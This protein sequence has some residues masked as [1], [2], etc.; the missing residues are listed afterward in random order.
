MIGSTKFSFSGDEFSEFLK[1]LN[2][3]I[4]F[5]DGKNLENF[6]E[7]QRSVLKL[8]YNK[9]E[10]KLSECIIH[11]VFVDGEISNI[12]IS[13]ITF[14]N[15]KGGIGGLKSGTSQFVGCSF[16][17][18]K[19]LNVNV[20]FLSCNLIESYL[21]NSRSFIKFSEFN[22]FS[23]INSNLYID[24]SFGHKGNI[25]SCTNSY[26][27]IKLS[28]LCNFKFS[29]NF[30]KV[31]IRSSQILTCDISQIFVYDIILKNNNFLNSQLNT[32]Q[33][34]YML[35]HPPSDLFSFYWM[36]F[37]HP[38]NNNLIKY[39]MIHDSNNHPDPEKFNVWAKNGPCPYTRSISSRMIDFS[40]N[41]KL[42]KDD[43][44]KLH[45]NSWALIN[46]LFKIANIKIDNFDCSA[47]LP[48]LE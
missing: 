28:Y 27:I 30:H 6:N 48:N 39:A 26:L 43:Y 14:N 10:D 16:R 46:E 24:F 11:D 44:Y 2:N 25:Q 19:F 7:K 40:E 42:W 8:I 9:K 4:S 41:R 12:S 47:E 31:D 18:C 5:S 17:F 3:W 23:S 38:S 21:E 33:A 32:V 20:D 13:N 34:S 29:G 36:S 15:L 1:N 22:S 37:D 45:V 35:V